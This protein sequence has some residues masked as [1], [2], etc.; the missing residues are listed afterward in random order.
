MP[1]APFNPATGE[2][3][4]LGAYPPRGTTL[5][6]FQVVGDD[7]QDPETA[8]THDNYVVCRGYEADSDP[9]F[10]YLHD[11]YTKADTTPINVAKP[12]SIRGTF[13]YT[14]GQVIVAARIKGRLGYNAGM[15]TLP[16]VG[17]PEDLTDELEILLD[18]GGVGIAWL[19]IGTPTSLIGRCIAHLGGVA[20]QAADWTVGDLYDVSGG[21]GLGIVLP[22]VSASVY[23]VK[24][25]DSGVY[26]FERL[27]TEQTIINPLPFTLNTS[28]NVVFCEKHG[29]AWVICGCEHLLCFAVGVANA[30]GSGTFDYDVTASVSELTDVGGVAQIYSSDSTQIELLFKADDLWCDVS[31]H[32][33]ATAS[34]ASARV[35]VELLDEVGNILL[36]AYGH[37]DASGLV[38]LSGRRLYQ[39]SN[40]QRLRLTYVNC[41]AASVA[42]VTIRPVLDMI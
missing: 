41:Q 32:V 26:H 42:Y 7:P 27:A 36:T 19:D 4:P 12:Y 34:P 18:D 9:N 14:Q 35:T 33:Q 23:A 6:L 3:A 21:T 16:T 31:F 5:A 22:S 24:A 10:R 13:P 25:D 30:S 29:S 37:S 20:V 1:G 17:Q 15:A 11:P 8:D 2:R 38:S 28:G 39:L 40:L